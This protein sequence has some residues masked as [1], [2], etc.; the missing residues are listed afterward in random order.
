MHRI[1]KNFE[2]LEEFKRHERK[3]FYKAMSIRK[4][5]TAN[6]LADYENPTS[7]GYS[8]NILRWI[9]ENRK[10]LLLTLEAAISFFEVKKY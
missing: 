6:E 7:F 1:A 4:S 9:S 10:L 5:L 3:I 8:F 2:K